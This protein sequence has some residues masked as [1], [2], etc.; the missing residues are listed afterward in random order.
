MNGW[1]YRYIDR[2]RK[3]NKDSKIHIW[4]Y[5]MI[6]GWMYRGVQNMDRW[7][8]ETRERIKTPL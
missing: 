2:Y 3:I 1:T 6:D 5:I 4:I 7:M 8:D